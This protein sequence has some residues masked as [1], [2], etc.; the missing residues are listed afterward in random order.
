MFVNIRGVITGWEDSIIDP[1]I[2][3]VGIGGEADARN[4]AVRELLRDYY[5]AACY[6]GAGG[7]GAGYDDQD[8]KGSD[9]GYYNKGFSHIDE[10]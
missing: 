5:S 1:A 8:D 7:T 4:G 6:D 9:K 10:V 2:D 3:D